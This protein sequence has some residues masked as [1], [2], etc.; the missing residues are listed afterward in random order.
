MVLKFPLNIESD[1]LSTSNEPSRPRYKFSEKS[2]NKFSNIS[3]ESRF[4][5][6][7][8]KIVKISVTKD[9]SNSGMKINML[10]KLRGLLSLPSPGISQIRGCTGK[11]VSLKTPKNKSKLFLFI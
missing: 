3:E 2:V 10:S 11:I 1:T 4:V 7:S 6:V 5:L 8:V 9:E